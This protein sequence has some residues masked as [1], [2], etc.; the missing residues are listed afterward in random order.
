MRDDNKRFRDMA[1]QEIF[2]TKATQERFSVP[3]GEARVEWTH[4]LSEEALWA[5][6]GTLSHVAMLQGEEREDAL[7]LFRDALSGEGVVRNEKG[8]V[9]CHGWTYLAWTERL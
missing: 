3:L 9:E 1:W 4:W 2:A 6:I 7:R 5:R 8:E